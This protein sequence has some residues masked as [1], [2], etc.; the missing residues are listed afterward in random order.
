M[1]PKNISR[2][3]DF[4]YHDPLKSLWV[5]KTAQIGH[6][7]FFDLFC[8]QKELTF[9][10][11]FC[12]YLGVFSAQRHFKTPS[13]FVLGIF[14]GFLFFHKKTFFPPKVV[15]RH[16]GSI[17]NFAKIRPKNRPPRPPEAGGRPSS[18]GGNQI[19]PVTF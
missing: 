6:Y 12:L 14:V 16:S 8:P 4:A 13:R 15:Y 1:D 3:L 5:L 10:Q 9:L 17:C 2:F 7:A 11:C 18:L 19:G